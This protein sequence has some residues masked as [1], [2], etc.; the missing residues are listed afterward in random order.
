M[1][2]K[3]CTYTSPHSCDRSNLHLDNVLNSWLTFLS[4]ARPSECEIYPDIFFL[5]DNVR[6][7]FV[8]YKIL[9]ALYFLASIIYSWSVE[10]HGWKYLIYMTS[11]GICLLNF[12]VVLET[13]VVV[14]NYLNV[15]LNSKIYKGKESTY[16]SF[17]YIEILFLYFS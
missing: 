16:V 14:L 4:K 8:L 15:S 9:T 17:I 2:R 6:V 10:S 12:T 13:I 11:W 5:D 3:K 7:W 1:I